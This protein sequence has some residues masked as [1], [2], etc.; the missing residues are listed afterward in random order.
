M[1]NIFALTGGNFLIDL[2]KQL[3]F[4]LDKA[5]YSLVQF[6]YSVFYYLADA[7]ILNDTIVKN[8]TYRMYTLLGIV[9]VFVLAFNLLSYIVDP[10]KITDKKVGAASFVKDVLLAII[11]ITISPMLFTKLYALQAQIITSGVM[12]N[13]I[14]GGAT[15]EL[16]VS[17]DAASTQDYINH[18]GNSMVASVYVAFLYPEGGEFTALDCKPATAT[19]PS[20]N[21]NYAK[22]CDAYRKVKDGYG[23]NA[24][25]EFIAND[26]YNFTPLLT[27]VAGIVLLFFMLSF[28]INLAKRVG[29]MALVQLIAPVP[30]T[31]ELLPNK[32]GLRE[33][34]L[35]T[36]SKVY[37]EVFF[38]LAVMYF[39]MLLISLIP[40]TVTKLFEFATGEGLGPVKL[41]ATVLLIYGLLMFGKEAPQMLFDLLGIKSTGIIKEAAKR[42][43]AMPGVM[44]GAAATFGGATIGNF[45]RNISSTDGNIGK[46]IASGFAGAG[47]SLAR[48]IWGLRNVHSA[49]DLTNL[50]KNTNK[51]V[52]T[53]RV[54][55]AAYS[56]AHGG[57][58][59]G[60][61]SGHVSDMMRQANLSAR[62]YLGA[63]NDYQRKRNQDQVLQDYKRLYAD[64]VESLWKNDAQFS[65]ADADA[66]K[67]KAYIA[68][69][70]DDMDKM[71]GKMY[72]QLQAEAEAVR[73]QR[74]IKVIQE[75]KLQFMEA[76]G[77]INNFIDANQGVDGVTTS[78]LDLDAIANMNGDL[79][80]EVELEK[81][82]MAV[83][84]KTIDGTVVGDGFA[85]E[86]GKLKNDTQYQT[87]RIQDK[88]REDAKNATKQA[89]E[90]ASNKGD[91]DKK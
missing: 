37:L 70:G 8:F 27:T 24:F 25:S 58:L 60:V 50:R 88:L 68:A 57:T 53:A 73:D 5:V 26:D 32:K 30:V 41:L 59:G 56:H 10:D 75:K 67:Y 29:K 77:K 82:N 86:L 78:R 4:A 43:L 61:M 91:K 2:L 17:I 85:T 74:R 35:K 51:A 69:N 39:I 83:T 28:C 55:R 63:D 22:Y 64:N 52:V 11:I 47:S 84:G 89:A 3:T 9:M 23:L 45:A 87:E 80:A 21:G 48:N 46:K 6:A 31:L 33:N 90:Q 66:K 15:S 65:A 14:L 19:D 44:A 38:Y 79:L 36:L 34:W 62:N 1:L 7:S 16:G 40:G 76:A 71:T 20:P 18:G 54:N 13:L 49:K 12:E 81:V 42:A 72:S